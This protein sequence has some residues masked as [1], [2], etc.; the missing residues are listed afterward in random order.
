MYKVVVLHWLVEVDDS[1][2][3]RVKSGQQFA[4]DDHEFQRISRIGN[5]SS[6]FSSA[7]LSRTCFLP[8]GWIALCEAHAEDRTMRQHDSPFSHWQ[9]LI[10]CCTPRHSRRFWTSPSACTECK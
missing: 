9:D 3:R 7:P 2:D 5:R 1:Q 10:M 6:S 4:G 8:F